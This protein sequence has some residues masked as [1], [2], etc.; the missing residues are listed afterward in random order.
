MA[1]PLI[2]RPNQASLLYV[3]ALEAAYRTGTWIYDPDFATLQDLEIWE[4]INRDPVARHAISQR[5]HSVA[6]R[7]WTIAPADPDDEAC[8]LA[9]KIIED[10]LRNLPRFEPARLAL[11][12]AVFRG[13]SYAYISGRREVADFGGLG[14]RSWWAPKR[15]QDIDP[16]RVRY[17]PVRDDAGRLIRTETEFYSLDVEKRFDDSER[18]DGWV[19]MDRRATIEVIYDDEETRLGYGR[20]LL[21][22]MYFSFYAKGQVLRFGLQGAGR[23]AMGLLVGKVDPTAAGSASKSN[24]TLRNA[25]RDELK[26]HRTDHVL[27]MDARDE[28]EVHESSGTGH[29]IVT[30]LI[31]YFDRTMTQLALG[32][33]LPT[34]GGQGE[35]GSFARAKVEMESTEVLV[36]YD[37]KLLHGALSNDLIGA[38]WR[39]N[40]RAFEALC[41]GA[42]KP[43]MVPVQERVDKPETAV[44][45]A[46]ALLEMG[47]PIGKEEVYEK[48]GF[49]QPREGDEVFD[50]IPEPAM[51]GGGGG[52]PDLALGDNDAGA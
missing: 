16:R 13:R 46:K 11:A 28:I 20:G 47:V 45:V 4:K 52:L 1:L 17:T 41:P 8:I 26:K 22:S 51:A 30:D 37:A 12:K 9:A 25:M 6:G 2:I 44:L 49:S 29:K 36:Q 10:M 3:R 32:S 18:H 14:P 39:F 21:E 50:S 48:T 31:N 27:T 19:P 43:K 7:S 15:L 35:S 42:R 5:I 38:I 23:W 40:R 24:E 33:V 34:G